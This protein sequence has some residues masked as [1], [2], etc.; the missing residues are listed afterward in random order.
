MIEKDWDNE[1]NI[2]FMSALFWKGMV[3][4]MHRKISVGL[5]MTLIIIGIAVAI[6]V[7]IP[8][9]LYG[10]NHQVGIFAGGQTNF[11]KL[12]EIDKNVKKYFLD[13]VDEDKLSAALANGYVSALGDD[14]AQYLDN[15]QY[16]N[17]ISMTKG[18]S[19]GLGIDIVKPPDNHYLYVAAVAGKS[20]AEAVGI[21][22]GDLITKINGKATETLTLEEAVNIIKESGDKPVALAILSTGTTKELS[23]TPADFTTDAVD[24]RMIGTIGYIK[25]DTFGDET[26][27]QFEEALKGVMDKNATALIFDLRNN[28]GGTVDSCAKI[29]DMLLPSGDIVKTKDKSGNIKVDN[30][31]DAKEISLPMDVLI[32]GGTASASE[33]FAMNIKDYN[34]GK[35]VGTKSYGKGIVQTTFQLSDNTAVKFTTGMFIDKNGNA[36]H[37]K[38]FEPDIK[39]ELSAEQQ[40]YFAMLNDKDDPQ[41]MAAVNDLN[42]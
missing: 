11:K 31:S 29:L 10:V 22:R 12:N 27:P 6:S 3:N 40:K 33:L 17:K 19:K 39:V 1:R 37:K 35:L 28:S 30:K 23:V 5:C 34:K 20:P 7:T 9:T 2:R 24:Y 25:I 36:Y 4:C 32:N 41:L 18:E 42:Q 38:G 14:Y 13:K 16:E 21:V 26:V 15:K 8:L